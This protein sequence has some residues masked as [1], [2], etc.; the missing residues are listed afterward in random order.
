MKFDNFNY[1]HVI[2][3]T[4]FVLEILFL[5]ALLCYILFFMK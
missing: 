4:L 5:I 3:Y 2:W 1:R